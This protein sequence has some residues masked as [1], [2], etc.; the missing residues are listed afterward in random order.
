MATTRTLD[1]GREAFLRQEWAEA[2]SM[3]SVADRDERL[4]PPDLQM[5]ATAAHLVGH[6]TVPGV[7]Q[8]D[9]APS[10]PRR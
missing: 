6:E 8:H 10:G 5:L 7:V 2:Y 4:A 9:V 1:Q 3:L